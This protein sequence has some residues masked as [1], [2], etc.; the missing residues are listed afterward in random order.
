MT[1]SRFEELVKE[2]HPQAKL[3]KHGEFAGSKINVAIIFNGEH[4]RVYNYNGTYCDVL[5]KLG[6]K[7]VYK[8]NYDSAKATL[9]RYIQDNGTECVFTGETL[10][11]TEQIA[12][13]TAIVQDMETNC[14]IV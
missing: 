13:W 3:F 6:I 4:G 9:E 7:A 11:N 1:F 2:K 10:D 14:V 8:H 5:N 12:S